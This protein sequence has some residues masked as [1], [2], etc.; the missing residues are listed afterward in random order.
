MGWLYMTSLKGHVGPR[1]YLDAQYTYDHDETSLRVLKSCLAKTR[2]YYAAV[3]RTVQSSRDREVFAVVCLVNYNLR[4][5]EGYIF[6]YKDMTEFMGPYECSCPKSI[7]DLLTPTDNENANGW[8]KRCRERLEEQRMR[9]RK[10]M[11]RPGQT[12]LF[13]SP[14]SFTDGRSLSELRAIPNPR[15][16]RHA[17]LF[18]DSGSGAVY[19]IRNIK[20]H[21]YRLVA[22]EGTSP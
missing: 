2:V 8:R 15:G 3:E 10:P 11:P 12:I 7:L 20:D 21:D 1:Q 19:R 6:G 5:P 9:V 18:Q 16:G 13:D 14:I 17:V 22:P 4:D